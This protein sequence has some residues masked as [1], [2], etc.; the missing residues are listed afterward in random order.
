LRADG[1][2]CV[3]CRIVECI[4]NFISWKNPRYNSQDTVNGFGGLEIFNCQRD[5][6]NPLEFNPGQPTNQ[7]YLTLNC[8]RVNVSKLLSTS[9]MF[10]QQCHH[11]VSH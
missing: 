7:I 6:R 4:K 8:L 3:M 2:A 10:I 11:K 1:N 9:L 5:E